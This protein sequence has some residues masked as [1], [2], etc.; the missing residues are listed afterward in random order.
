[1]SKPAKKAAKKKA[2]PK[3]QEV[4]SPKPAG[5]PR[6]LI[7]SPLSWCDEI[8]AET[9]CPICGEH[10]KFRLR[11]PA[12]GEDV[13]RQHLCRCEGARLESGFVFGDFFWDWTILPSGMEKLQAKWQQDAW[14][15]G[16]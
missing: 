16:F 1:M 9:S 11:K 4:V 5:P 13:F 14:R 2:D 10:Y 6:F 15:R 7:P 12:N 8:D 3:S